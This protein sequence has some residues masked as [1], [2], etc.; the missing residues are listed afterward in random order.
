MPCVPLPH[1]APHLVQAN[2]VCPIW[3]QPTLKLQLLG[4]TSTLD[5]LRQERDLLQQ[6]GR[7]QCNGCTVM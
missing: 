4:G 6:L 1:L 3:D 5:R 7:A 2:L